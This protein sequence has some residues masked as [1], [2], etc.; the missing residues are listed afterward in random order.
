VKYEEGL[1]RI[2]TIAGIRE[3]GTKPTTNAKAESREVAV[4]LSAKAARAIKLY[5]QDVNDVETATKYTLAE[6]Q[7]RRMR[8]ENFGTT[9][10]DITKYA[11]DNIDK[12]VEHGFTQ[13]DKT[14][15]EEKAALYEEKNTKADLRSSEKTGATTSLMDA[16]ALQQD[17]VEILD[18]YMEMMKEGFTDFYNQYTAARVVSNTGI[19]HLPEEPAPP[20][21]A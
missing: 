9:V 13:D 12:L 7:L 15:L 3:G 14:K 4:Q 20:P 2:E 17:L 21:A 5:A 10:T 6:W 18:D 1:V 8:D 16:F 19:R 11:V